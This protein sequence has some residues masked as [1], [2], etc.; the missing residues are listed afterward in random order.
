MAVLVVLAA[1]AAPASQTSSDNLRSG[2]Y[3]DLILADEPIMYWRL[4]EASG[5][6]AY[7]ETSNHRDA[8]YLKRPFLGLN[9]AIRGDQNTSVG[10]NGF[11]QY[12]RWF[13]TS[14]ESGT[15]SVEAWIRERKVSP[16]QV[17]TFFDTR[18]PGPEYSF[19]FKLAWLDQKALHFDIGDGS[20]WLWTGG[21][22]FD[23]QRG[24][25]YYVAAVVTPSGA[26]VYVD[27]D[28]VG[29]VIYS[30][31]PLLFDPAHTVQIGTNLPFQEWFHGKIDEVAVYDYALTNEQIAAHY[32]A[33]TAL[34]ALTQWRSGPTE[35]RREIRRD[36]D[37][38]SAGGT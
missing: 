24:V 8:V 15:F 18:P 6:V 17:Q 31:T 28:S 13:P 36:S 11:D 26:T 22:P 19:D 25:W 5:T 38:R 9:G 23:F 32:S 34:F 35:V 4:G 37:S 10:F 21:L 3:R 12:A 20:S 7:D 2:S 29:S 16:G 27:G 1:Q 30:G 33:G 14:S